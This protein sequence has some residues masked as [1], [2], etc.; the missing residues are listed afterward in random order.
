LFLNNLENVKKERKMDTIIKAESGFTQVGEHQDPWFGLNRVE[1]YYFLDLELDN[2][3]YYRAVDIVHFKKFIRVFL[4]NE[5]G[6][7]PGNE[8]LPTSFHPNIFTDYLVH[9]LRINEVRSS[10]AVFDVDEKKIIYWGDSSYQVRKL[11]RRR[12]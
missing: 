3:R 1:A 9:Q 8:K 6:A 12:R 7:L 4:V 11:C 5:K 2:P 10:F